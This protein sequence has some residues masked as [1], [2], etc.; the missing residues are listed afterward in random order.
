MKKLLAVLLAAALINVV[1]VM[2]DNDDVEHLIVTLVNYSNQYPDIDM[3]AEAISEI[4]RE[5]IGVEVEIQ[6]SDFASYRQNI[7]LALSGGEQLDLVFTGILG[8]TNTALQGYLLDLNED[9]LLE[10]YGQG[11]IEAVGGMDNIN[12]AKVDG[13]VYGAPAIHDWATGHGCYAIRQDLLEEVG[14]EVTDED[15]VQATQEE[16][17][18]WLAKIHEK[19]PDIETFRPTGTFTNQF[20]DCALISDNVFGVLLDYG[21]EPVVENLFTSESYLKNLMVFRNYYLNGYISKDAATDTTSV[22]T[23]MQSDALAAYNTGGKPGIR[24]QES[25]ISKPVVIFQTKEDLQNNIANFTWSIPYTTADPVAAMKL[26]N[27][28]YSNPE[29]ANILAYGIEGVHYNL[30]DGQVELVENPG[31]TTLIWDQPNE[32]QLYTTTANDPDVWERTKEF[33]ENCRKPVSGGFTFDPTPVSDQI[34]ACQNVYEEYQKSLEYGLVDPEPAIEEMNER[35]MGCGLQDIIDEKQR[36]L[37][38][39]LA[40]QEEEATEA[41]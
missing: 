18:G 9:D 39:W 36:Q 24:A 32:L 22:T 35:L 4:T 21:K 29:V 14:Y 41:E 12:A 34:S 37:D 19:F 33:N 13:I 16:V 6:M 15:I 1:P 23:L 25:R 38:E 17:D 28:F 31:Y 7:T 27:E 3:V 11:V 10:T 26:M 20:M 30:V 40:A 2:A 8:Y 5:S